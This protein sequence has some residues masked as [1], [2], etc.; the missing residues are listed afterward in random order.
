MNDE[1]MAYHWLPCSVVFVSTVYEEKRD[2]MTA[3]RPCLFRKKSL[4]WPSA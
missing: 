4:W 2:I 3:L 1:R